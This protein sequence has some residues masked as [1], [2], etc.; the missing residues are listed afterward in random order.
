MP[1]ATDTRVPLWRGTDE[2]LRAYI[3]DDLVEWSKR[4][5]AETILV[6]RHQQ[7][8]NPAAFA[9]QTSEGN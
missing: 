2:Q 6:N 8:N 3:D 7:R 4:Q 5:T 9:A 1:N